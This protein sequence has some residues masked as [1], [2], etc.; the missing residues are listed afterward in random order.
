[1][2]QKIVMEVSMNSSKHRTKA[3]KI[4][5]VADGVNSVE[6]EGTDKVVVTGEVD[7]VKLAHAL[8]KKF[9]HV[10]IVSVK[11]EKEEKEEKKTEEKD[12]LYWPNNYFHHYPPP[13]MYGDV[14]SPH[15]PPTCSIL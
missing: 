15:Q 7:S 9:G 13:M 3:M 14:Y 1:M 12:V 11:E 6:I 5:A 4:A 10:M 2:K 8:R